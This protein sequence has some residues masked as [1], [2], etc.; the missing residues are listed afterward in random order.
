MRSGGKYDDNLNA[1]IRGDAIP[2]GFENRDFHRALASRPDEG[3][4][5]R[6]EAFVIPHSC[7]TITKRG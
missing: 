4:G 6:F 3:Q 7:P 2:L 1:T 5:E